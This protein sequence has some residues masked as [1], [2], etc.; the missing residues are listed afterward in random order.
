MPFRKSLT[1]RIVYIFLFHSPGSAAEDA[2]YT[3]LW[4]TIVR[5]VFILTTTSVTKTETKTVGV[6]S[7]ASPLRNKL[8]THVSSALTFPVFIRH[9]KHHFFLWCLPWIHCTNHQN[10]KYHAVH[11]TRS[12]P[13]PTISSL[14]HFLLGFCYRIVYFVYIPNTAVFGPTNFI[15]T[16]ASTT[17][18]RMKI[19][20]EDFGW[21]FREDF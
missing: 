2:Y 20:A 10:W 5:F 9:L 18:A 11:P 4:V 19:S 14:S 16:I 7:T 6:S 17:T 21:R 3:E 15:E 8:P 13:A 12:S 1:W